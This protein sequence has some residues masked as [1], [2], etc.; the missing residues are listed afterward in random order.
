MST[1]TNTTEVL[2][3]YPNFYRSR[4]YFEALNEA[5]NFIQEHFQDKVFP[6]Q[7]FMDIIKKAI[8]PMPTIN[9]TLTSNEINAIQIQYHKAED[10]FLKRVI[11]FSR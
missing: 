11:V 3:G 4:Y 7:D 6:E 8:G 5:S 9:G 10:L 2:Q 1:M